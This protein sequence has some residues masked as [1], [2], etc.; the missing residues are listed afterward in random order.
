MRSL[1]LDNSGNT[2]H[3]QASNDEPLTSLFEDDLCVLECEVSV[4]RY[5]VDPRHVAEHRVRPRSG[6]RRPDPGRSGGPECDRPGAER[7]HNVATADATVPEQRFRYFRDRVPMAVDQGRCS[8]LLLPLNRGP[9]FLDKLKEEESP[10]LGDVV[11]GPDEVRAAH[12]ALLGDGTRVEARDLAQAAF[13]RIERLAE[14]LWLGH[15]ALS[16]P[17]PR[18]VQLVAYDRVQDAEPKRDTD[19]G[20]TRFVVSRGPALKRRH[21][22]TGSS[23]SPRRSSGR[24][25]RLRHRE[26]FCRR[27]SAAIQT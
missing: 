7:G 1:S 2:L 6:P 12:G 26:P 11:A 3:M 27:L 25:G 22:A 16:G 4:L 21:A 8:G 5:C 9:V 17:A 19:D 24:A 18:R 13:I 14:Q 10:D 15:D 23:L 20:V